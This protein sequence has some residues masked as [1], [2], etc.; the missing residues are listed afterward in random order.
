MRAYSTTHPKLLGQW[1]WC[2]LS[3]TKYS[4]NMRLV[5]PLC[6]VKDLID[7]PKQLCV[8]D[9]CASMNRFK[10]IT[11][12]VYWSRD[13]KNRRLN[14]F[15]FMIFSSN[16]WYL[17]VLYMVSTSLPYRH[18]ESTNGSYFSVRSWPING[19]QRKRSCSRRHLKSFHAL[20]VSMNARMNQLF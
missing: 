14:Q 10:T 1:T 11:P 6:L 17:Y 2:Q 19:R 5:N 15:L 7:Q 18:F 13:I 9:S 8:H 4:H 12:Q 20:H 3:M 16:I